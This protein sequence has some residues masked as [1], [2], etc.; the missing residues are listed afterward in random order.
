MVSHIHMLIG[1]D[2]S[3]LNRDYCARTILDDNCILSSLFFSA[4]VAREE[5]TG[6]W[7]FNYIT[8]TM[9]E[10]PHTLEVNEKQ[11]GVE[12]DQHYLAIKLLLFWR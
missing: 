5:R 7:C 8:M 2:R 9:H 10:T 3:A 1:S 4:S 11:G 12:G 6:D